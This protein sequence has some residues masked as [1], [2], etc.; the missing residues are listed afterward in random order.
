MVNGPV[1]AAV[2]PDRD[3]EGILH[4]PEDRMMSCFRL[5]LHHPELSSG[6]PRKQ[7]W[8]ELRSAHRRI[9]QAVQLAVRNVILHVGEMRSVGKIRFATPSE[10]MNLSLGIPLPSDCYLPED[11]DRLA[12]ILTESMKTSDTTEY[13]YSSV[14]RKLLMSEFAKSKLNSLLKGDVSFPVMRNVG[15][16]MRNRNWSIRLETRVVDGKTYVDPVV[17]TSAFR[18]GNGGMILHCRS[19]HAGK[20]ERATGLLEELATAGQ[21][22]E[23]A[24]KWRKGALIIRPVRRPGQM[25]KWEILIPYQSPRKFSGGQA[26]MSVH[27]S[28]ANMLTAAVIDG[29]KLK[30]H[31]YPGRA[32]VALKSQLYARRRS[33][34]RDLAARM[35]PMRQANRKHYRALARLSDAEARATQTE[36][37]RAARWVQGVA[38]SV[39]AQ[40]IFMDDFTSFDPDLPGP[41]MEPYVRRFPWSDLKDKAVDALTRRAGIKVQERK[42]AYITQRCPKCRISSKDNLVKM[43]KIRGTEVE[44][45][46]WKCC[47]PGCG[48][49]GDPDAIAGENLLADCREKFPGLVEPG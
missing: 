39:G 3:V 9:G 38:E 46:W 26:I 44:T 2:E 30:I 41:P 8:E 42:S 40:V 17:E 18:K 34:S 48:K 23:T 32:V 36:L 6:L 11:L 13:V 33:I 5:E 47:N 16:M 15:L 22:P 4:E 35:H 14:A 1:T 12:D 45:G 49:E 25:D 27:R 10:K 24:N 20:L 21:L 37:W 43:P 29:S 28:V 7:A 19:L 31:H